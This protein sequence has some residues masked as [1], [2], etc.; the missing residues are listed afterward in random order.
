[1]VFNIYFINKNTIKDKKTTTIEYFDKNSFLNFLDENI[2]KYPSGI[3][4][5][6]IDPQNEK[7]SIYLKKYS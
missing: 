4:Q 1:M 2:D 6:F 3:L 7:N 5:R